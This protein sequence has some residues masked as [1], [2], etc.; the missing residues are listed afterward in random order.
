MSPE[1]P[2]SSNNL[3][4][5]IFA[6]IDIGLLYAFARRARLY[7]KLWQVS[8]NGR[9]ASGVVAALLLV[10]LAL[11]WVFMVAT[12]WFDW[13]I[14]LDPSLPKP[15]FFITWLLG[16]VPFGVCIGLVDV[17]HSSAQGAAK[18]G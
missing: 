17:L 16:A 6:L 11:L 3:L 5:L 9:Y 13:R 18:S 15:Y 7:Y 8:F 10:V 12:T 1:G 14:S 2:V 4:F